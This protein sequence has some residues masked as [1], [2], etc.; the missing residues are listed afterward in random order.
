VLIISPSSEEQEMIEEVAQHHNPGGLSVEATASFG[1]DSNWWIENKPDV[2]IV[3]LPEDELLQEYYFTKLHRDIPRTQSMLFLC[4]R[5]SSS[6]MQMSLNFAKVRMIKTPV[7]S[8]SLYRALIDLMRD[9]EPGQQQSH[10]RYLTD[11]EIEVLSDFREGKLSAKMKNLSMSGAY[12]EATT[13]SLELA[14]GDFIRLSVAVGQPKK[15]YI[16]DAKVV[17][18]KPQSTSG[19]IGYGVTFINKEEVYNNLLKNI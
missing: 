16:F 18:M 8:F 9:F 5:I 1:Q 14:P 6:L 10:P 4:S 3:N 12:F 13:Q 15:Q 2:L 7:E 17:W 11:Q 19:L